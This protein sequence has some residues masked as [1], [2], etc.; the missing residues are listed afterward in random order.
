MNQNDRRNLQTAL[1]NMR[2]A[3]DAKTTDA[4]L[5]KT[6]EAA[7]TPEI[8]KLAQPLTKLNGVGDKLALEILAAVGR[9]LLDEEPK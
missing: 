3:T 1:A 6:I 7:A 2:E 4:F 9:I 8:R 5:Q